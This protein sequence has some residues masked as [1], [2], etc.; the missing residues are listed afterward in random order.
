MVEPK[1]SYRPSEIEPKWQRFW[2]E[3]RVF[4]APN[5]GDADFDA[6]KPKFY[7]LDMFP[8]PSGAGL[9]VG[10]P[11]GYTATDIVSR[12]K[13]ATGHNVLHPMGWDAFG[14]PAE[15]YA[16]QTGRHP[17]D[18][19][20]E[21]VDN[22]RRQ[23][24]ALGFSYDWDRE[25]GTCDPDY[26]RWTQW[27]FKKLHEQGLAYL[28]NAPVWWCEA[29]G[30]VLS[31]DEVVGGRS[32]R[33]D[34]PCERRP[35]RQWVLKITA[36]AERLLRDLDGLDW[37]ESLKTQ[38]REWIGRS[39]G[40]EIDFDVDGHDARIRVF[41][42]RPDTLFGASF[43]VL[44]PEHPLVAQI[45][46]ADQKAAIDAYVKTAAAKSELERTD[47]AKE[48][49][50][51]F[52][53]CYALN[54]IYAADD[55]RARIPVWI[56]D[57]VL[58]SY[59]T[60]AIMAVPAGDERDFEFATE[61]G[62]PVPAI[63]APDT[64]DAE[65]DAAVAAGKA[66][67]TVEAPYANSANDDGLDLHGL[68]K[69]DAIRA[70]ID[71]LAARDR[72]TAK[73]QFRMRDWLFSRQR[74]WG[75]PFPVLFR[76]DG[77]VELVGDDALP[78]ELPAM[79]DFTPHGTPESPLS[80][81]VEW[82]ATTAADGTPAIR[83][84]NTMPGAAGSSWYFLRFC[85]PKNTEEFCSKA[86]SDYW[87]PVDLYVGGTEHA[88]GHLLYSRFW[89]KVLHDLGLVGV[90]EPFQK[91]YNQGMILSF[92]YQ[93][94]RGATVPTA[95]AEDLGDGKYRHKETG[96][97]LQQIVTKMS[98][99][100]GN[101]V[102]PDDVVREYGADTLRLYEMYMGPLADPKPWNP[103]DVPGV[104]RFL[105]RVWRL[106]VPED[107]EAGRLH[108]HLGEDKPT[109]PA[110]ER[111]LHRCIDK[112]TGDIGR[113]AFNTAIAAMM[114][115]V[116]DATKAVDRLTADQLRRFVQVLAPFAPHMAEELYERL[117]GEGLLAYAA[118]PTVDPALLVDDEVEI[119]VQVLGKVR[120]RIQV[121]KDMP[122]DE[123]L[124]AARAAVASQLEGKTVVK[125]IVVPGKI[126]NFVVR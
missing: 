1:Q 117:G 92:A 100:Y 96:Q 67:C 110:L 121:A 76:E 107:A 53:G 93:D 83:E 28:S 37:T 38:Q 88:V 98:K 60:G 113:M 23:L 9:H 70:T 6:S 29:L 18:T 71:W 91:L 115:F 85:D 22:F 47:L 106:C 118:W 75:E 42:T 73:V 55:P 34:H 31:N 12:F 82:T 66:C 78:V 101:V 64:G 19:T 14:L 94:E 35:L 61:F 80:R 108:A 40:A 62:I 99:R 10:H 56:A 26:F 50:G 57:Y 77:Q 90:N 97:A 124:A 17:A 59:G 89:T 32:E 111:A 44:A 69:Q 41:T 15:Q 3:N 79:E 72:G 58:A 16:I 52:T 65:H 8:Y 20:R 7:A 114:V 21:N 116:N 51:V 81:A 30:T 48:K 24:K 103:K 87:L 126:V 63:F 105:S 122:K 2:D 25:F 112:V 43:M 119:A 54:P 4:R 45:T 84:I 102:N 68:G 36:Y 95:M 5:P 11:E 33:G 125:E 27:I 86:A 49:T 123:V 13:R 120:A 39:E 46:T 74:Y 104:H 109:D